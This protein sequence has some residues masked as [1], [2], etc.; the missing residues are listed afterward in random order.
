MYCSQVV[1]DSSVGYTTDSFPPA[2]D[3]S[4]HSHVK[5]CAKDIGTDVAGSVYHISTSDGLDA[6]VTVCAVAAQS[7]AYFVLFKAIDSQ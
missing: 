3:D 7:P 2:N 6:S 5:D 1:V 4:W